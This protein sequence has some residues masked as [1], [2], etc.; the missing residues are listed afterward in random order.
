ME[1]SRMRQG[2]VYVAVATLVIVSAA[3]AY[4]VYQDRPEAR[5]VEIRIYETGVTMKAQ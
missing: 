2:F 5:G 3:Y 4:R 1:V